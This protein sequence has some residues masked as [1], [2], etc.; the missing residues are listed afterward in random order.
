MSKSIVY[1][2]AFHDL[3][4]LEQQ[5]RHIYRKKTSLMFLIDNSARDKEG[6]CQVLHSDR[7]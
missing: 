1:A 3:N 4:D 7:R 6:T 2:A 5:V